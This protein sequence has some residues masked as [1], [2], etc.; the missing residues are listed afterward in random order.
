MTNLPITDVSALPD[1][2]LR[3][4]IAET[5]ETLG[6]LKEELEQRQEDQQANE[7]DNLEQHFHDA[8][9]SLQTIRDFFRYLMETRRGQ[10]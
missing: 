7:V 5:E 3:K 6:E 1:K 9:L 10:G 8:E 4:L 2:K